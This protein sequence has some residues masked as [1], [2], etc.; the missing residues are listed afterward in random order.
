MFDILLQL[1]I[2]EQLHYQACGLGQPQAGQVFLS[3]VAYAQAAQS[4]PSTIA[5]RNGSNLAH[6]LAFQSQNRCSLA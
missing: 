4:P 3:Q 2:H 5:C 1:R 6:T